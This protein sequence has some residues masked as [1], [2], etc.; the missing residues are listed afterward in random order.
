M[1]LKDTQQ[2]QGHTTKHLQDKGETMKENRTFKLNRRIILLIIIVVLISITR[3]QNGF[4]TKEVL[5]MIT[6]TTQ[7]AILIAWM[8]FTSLTRAKKIYAGNLTKAR[9]PDMFLLGSFVMLQPND[10]TQIPTT[11]VVLVIAMILFL[12]IVC[13]YLI[14]KVLSQPEWT[15]EETMG[16]ELPQWE[17]SDNWADLFPKYLAGDV[18]SQTRT[19]VTPKK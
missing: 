5:R 14:G 10:P 7:S 8:R 15:E 3:A 17:T 16:A 6:L 4:N 2:R 13:P 19:R 1:R 18:D 12:F 11:T 9:R